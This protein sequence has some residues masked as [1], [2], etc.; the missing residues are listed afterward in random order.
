MEIMWGQRKQIQCH[1]CPQKDAEEQEGSDGSRSV[2][3]KN[4]GEY[5]ITD[6][7]WLFRFNKDMKP[8]TDEEKKVLATWVK[9]TWTETKKRVHLTR[10]KVDEIICRKP[11]AP[12]FTIS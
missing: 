8:L 4:C 5:G 2:D 11:P 9:N 3:C 10:Q 7:A 12:N 1:L 6:S